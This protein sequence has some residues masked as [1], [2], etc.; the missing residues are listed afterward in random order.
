MNNGK[1][2]RI[3]PYGKLYTHVIGY[4]SPIYGKSK[5]ELSY[6]DYLSGDSAI[7]TAMNIASAVTGDAKRGMDLTLTI[8]HKLQ[9][10]SSD[11]L[12]NKNGC[13]IV[14]DAETGKIRSMVSKPTFNP[15]EPLLSE[16]WGEL[17]ER[18]DSPFLA[19][20]T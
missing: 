1:G 8:D 2:E 20:A 19:R 16:S 18:E 14:M 9:S 17:A 5:L 7:G 15:S 13:I 4:N 3:Y 10:Y 12:G 11:V 6:N